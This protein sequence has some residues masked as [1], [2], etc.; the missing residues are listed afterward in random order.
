M[1]PLRTSP[2]SQA[3]NL[4][5][6]EVG[7]LVAL[8]GA[9]ALGMVSGTA[10]SAQDEAGAAAVPER[11]FK[12]TIPEHVPLKVKVKNEQRFKRMTNEH[13]A[14]ELEI[15]VTN[16][17]RKPIY[18][19]VVS[20]VLR[21]MADYYGY[22]LTFQIRYGRK[23]LRH[24]ETPLQP[25]D[26]PIQPGESVT[27]K[28]PES[29]GQGFESIRRKEKLSNPKKIE[30]NLQSINF[31]DGTG[32]SGHQGTPDSRPAKKQSRRAPFLQGALAASPPTFGI[33]ASAYLESFHKAFYLIEPAN[34]LRVDFFPAE[35]A[36]VSFST[37]PFPDL[38]NCQNSSDC[39]FGIIDEPGCP[40]DDNS[41]FDAHLPAGS[42][43][44]TAG[45]CFRTMTV[46]PTCDTVFNDEQV[47]T[48]E[49]RTTSCAIGDPT[50]TPTPSPTPTPA[51]TPTPTPIPCP[52]P[53]PNFCCTCVAPVG[54]PGGQS[55]WD[56][57]SCPAGH[58]ARYCRAQGS[59]I[60]SARSLAKLLTRIQC[61]T[62][63]M[64]AKE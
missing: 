24:L 32:L 4:T 11:E 41:D 59:M 42:C 52:D 20:I 28:I 49:M 48:Y 29:Q 61:L 43:G 19:M 54:I 34:F 6:M 5:V 51:P 38:C 9:C 7:L 25:D 18:S 45:R 37:S 40:C 3:R 44:N 8:L 56:C 46:R 39:T 30:F 60:R 64:L 50:P 36:L 57:R 33:R 12:S 17:G 47:C 22:P 21:E 1:K 26:V 55:Y 58:A 23:E 62:Q 13:W 16:I 35:V 27:L 10:H 63:A 53:P 14:R 2:H 15:E 31:G